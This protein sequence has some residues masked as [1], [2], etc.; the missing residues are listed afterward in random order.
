VASTLWFQPLVKADEDAT[1]KLYKLFDDDWEFQLE[2]N[3]MSATGFGDRRYNDRL[4]DPSQAAA[5]EE[6]DQIEAFL[7]RLEAIDRD[8]LGHEDK[9]NY[10]VYKRLREGDL[11][12]YDFHMYLTP[13]TNRWGFHVQFAQLPDDVPLRTVEGPLILWRQTPR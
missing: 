6:R 10:D 9:I 3:P 4:P 12:R 5:K 11:G 13:I 7:A 2:R 8:A 1:Q